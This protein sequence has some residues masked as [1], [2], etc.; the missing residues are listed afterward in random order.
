M[1]VDGY[2]IDIV[3]QGFPGKS[4][5]H[6]GLGWSAV[7]LISGQGRVAL[8]DVGSFG[9]R[10]LLI[11]RLAKRG[12]TPGDVTDVILTH[13]HHD[14]SVN[15]TLFGQGPDRDWRARVGLVRQGALG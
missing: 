9:M 1:Q 2:K 3:V 12:L 8:I 15:W 4:V 14:H 5:C 10:R 7:V 11:E 13:S 6:G